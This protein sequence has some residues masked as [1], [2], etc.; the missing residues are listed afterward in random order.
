MLLSHISSNTALVVGQN[1]PP[2]SDDGINFTQ[3]QT[4]G[5]IDNKAIYILGD[6]ASI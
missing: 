6:T 5:L 3:I 4:P 2:V 1:Q